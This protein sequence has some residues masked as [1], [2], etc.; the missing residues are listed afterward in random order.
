MWILEFQSIPIIKFYINVWIDLLLDILQE[1]K[2]I[3]RK[4][5][6]FL[7]P[8]LIENWSNHTKLSNNLWYLTFYMV[9][10]GVNVWASYIS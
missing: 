7:F 6:F 2:S 3:G 9:S 1:H 5:L 10:W 4:S 8:A